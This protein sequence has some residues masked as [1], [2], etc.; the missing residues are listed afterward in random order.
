SWAVTLPAG[1]AKPVVRLVLRGKARPAAR[2]GEGTA[3]PEVWV[4]GVSGE[5]VVAIDAT[6]AAE[7]PVGLAALPAAQA[8]RQEW[9]VSEEGWSL[10]LLPRETPGVARA[11]LTEHRV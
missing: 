4:A 5:R 2:D 10:R 11:L 9:R 3:M 6:L 1:E 7:P 8:G